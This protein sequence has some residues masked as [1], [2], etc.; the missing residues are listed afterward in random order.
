M[1]RKARSKDLS[2]VPDTVDASDSEEEEEIVDVPYTYQV[3]NQLYW[4]DQ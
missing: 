2:N 3:S 4:I 1:A